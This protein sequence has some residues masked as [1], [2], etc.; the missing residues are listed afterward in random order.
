MSYPPAK[1]R[2]N[3]VYAACHRYV[4]DMH[5]LI[6]EEFVRQARMVVAVMPPG[7][8]A[9]AEPSPTVIVPVPVREGYRDAYRPRKTL[10]PRG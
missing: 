4:R 8:H 10:R 2:Q 7:R 6:Y 1:R 5:P 3:L 9:V